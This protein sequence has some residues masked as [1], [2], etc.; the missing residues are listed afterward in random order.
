MGSR[1]EFEAGASFDTLD[2]IKTSLLAL[3]LFGRTID[4]VSI[5]NFA[6]DLAESFDLPD[7]TL[8]VTSEPLDMAAIKALIEEFGQMDL[9]QPANQS[10]N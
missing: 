1:K 5:L 2:E 8:S 4:K 6:Q 9:N 3:R 7:D 10:R